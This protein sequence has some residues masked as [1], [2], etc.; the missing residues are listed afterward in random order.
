MGGLLPDIFR[1]QFGHLSCWCA[2]AKTNPKTKS[3]HSF[4][5]IAVMNEPGPQS[6]YKLED[7]FV[8]H[9]LAPEQIKALV[10]IFVLAHEQ[11]RSPKIS[12]PGFEVCCL[13]F[14]TLHKMM[15]KSAIIL[16]HA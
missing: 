12:I 2:K 4:W 10:F 6:Y 16:Q 8:C 3:L 14:A 7:W 1:Q 11:A 9:A 5:I 15:E 13:L